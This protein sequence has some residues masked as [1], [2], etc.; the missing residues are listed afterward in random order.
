MTYRSQCPGYNPKLLNIKQQQNSPF[1]RKKDNQWRL[2]KNN[3]KTAKPM[4]KDIKK[5]S[6]SKE[7]KNETATTKKNPNSEAENI[8]FEN[9]TTPSLLLN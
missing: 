5:K 1:S 8:M 3:F 7:Q 6:I 4:L 9:A 2:L